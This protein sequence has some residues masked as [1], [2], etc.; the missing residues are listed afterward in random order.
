MSAKSA[1]VHEAA[2]LD[3]LFHE[4]LSEAGTLISGDLNREPCSL[5]QR[6]KRQ[7]K[8]LV[9]RD[10]EAIIASLNLLGRNRIQQSMHTLA[11]AQAAPCVAQ[12]N[13]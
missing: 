8:Y 10:L 9:K 1:Q 3:G 7:S 5:H 11:R 6:S 12:A 4:L 2:S 13:V